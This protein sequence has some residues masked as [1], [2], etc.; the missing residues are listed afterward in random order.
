MILSILAHGLNT[1][2]TEQASPVFSPLQLVENNAGAFECALN[3]H[4]IRARIAPQVKPPPTPSI[5]TFCP[6][7]MRPSRTA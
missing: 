1:S 7:L 5:M 6:G 4:H 3:L 2:G